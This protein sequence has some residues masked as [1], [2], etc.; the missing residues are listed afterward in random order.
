M[1]ATYEP[2]AT[3]TLG[4]AARNIT[5]SSIPATYT[6]LRVVWVGTNQTAVDFIEITFNGTTSGYSWTHL[7]G[8]GS[9][10]ASG[11]ITSNTKWVPNLPSAGS[12]TIPYMFS[13]DLFSYGGSTFKTGL[14]T[15][16]ADTNG[17]GKVIC[18]VGLWQNTAAVTSIKLEGQSY[19]FNAGTTATLYG[20]KNA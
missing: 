15:C 16:S 12:T 14:M 8:D 4:T 9:A 13:V 5:F 2:I 7:S 19:N 1:P 6:D 17:A 10:A 11:R 20:I 18:S 3:T